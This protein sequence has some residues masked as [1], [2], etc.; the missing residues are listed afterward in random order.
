MVLESH[1]SSLDL[2]FDPLVRN[3]AFLGPD[4]FSYLSVIFAL[5]AGILYALSGTWMP[6]GGPW[7]MFLAL[8]FVGFNSIADT[9]DGRVARYTGRSSRGGDFLDHTFDRVSDVVILGGIALSPYS[10]TI[11]GLLAVISVL[12]ASYMGTQAQAVGC[13]RDYRGIMGRADRMVL[14]LFITPLQFALGIGWGIKGWK[15]LS[16]I[17]MDHSITPLE[18]LLAAMLIGGLITAFTR[19]VT[20]YRELR[21]ADQGGGMEGKNECDLGRNRGPRPRERRR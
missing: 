9:M 17:G 16:F 15:L 12:L 10:D 13:G 3:L 14:L 2:F 20:S 4:F 18:L 8:L 11:F 21:K 5:I 1:R 19:G 7:L 6:Q